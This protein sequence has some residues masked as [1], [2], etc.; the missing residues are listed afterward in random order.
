MDSP[1][2]RKIRQ[3]GIIMH[4]LYTIWTTVIKI[5]YFMRHDFNKILKALNI[6]YF[7]VGLGPNR[8][9]SFFEP[10]E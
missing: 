8:N 4:I 1:T 10:T 7:E 6:K 5:T 2:Y 9:T 3:L